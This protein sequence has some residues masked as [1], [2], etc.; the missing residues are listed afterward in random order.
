MVPGS[1]WENSFTESFNARLHELLDGEIFYTLQET[2]IV[3]ESWRLHYNALRPHASLGDPAPAPE[4]FVPAL[5]AWP[6]A[7]IRSAPPGRACP[8]A[9]TDH[10]L[11]FHPNHPG[12]AISG[13]LTAGAALT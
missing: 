12:G 2:R 9:E 7:H 8:G 13:D 11:T 6:A 3:I 1:Q 4:V 10:E 5:A